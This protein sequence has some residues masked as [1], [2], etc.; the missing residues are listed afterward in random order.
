[1]S[2]RREDFAAFFRALHREDIPNGQAGDSRLFAPFPWQERLLDCVLDT[3]SWPQQVVAPTGAGKTS[4][5]DVHVFGQAMCPAED[6]ERPPRRLA[7]VVDRRVLVDD[8]HEYAKR[9]QQR[10]LDAPEGTVLAEVRRALRDLREVGESY[11]RPLDES[12]VDSPLLVGR[13]RGGA[14]PSR[15]WRDHPTAAAIICGTPDM[16]GSRLLFRGYGSSSRAWPREAGLLAVDS[17][18]VVDEAHLARQLLVTARRVAELVQL[19]QDPVTW[20]ALQVVETTATP[21]QDIGEG[22]V[23]R[24]AT[25]V[26]ERDLDVSALR[27]RLTR[28]KPVKLVEVPDWESTKQTAKVITPLADEVVSLVA[29]T[30]TMPGVASTVGCFVNTV[31]RAVALADELR[32]RTLVGRPL[33]VVMIC[34]QVRP[35]D[36]EQVRTKHPGLLSAAGNGEV[37]V[38]VS[39]QS[40]EVGV[41]LDLAGIVTELASGSAVA[42]R[43][44]RVN[45]RGLRPAGP[46]VVTLPVGAIPGSDLGPG[47]TDKTR[48]GPYGDDELRT[49][50]GWL[51]ERSAD[52]QGLAPWQL[53]VH[54]PPAGARRRDH[55][56]QPQV[57]DAWHWA[58][59]SDEL[60][61]EPEL[62]LWLGEDF[63]QDTSAGLVVRNRMP[64][65]SA[66]A[67]QLVTALPPQPQEV[68][69]VPYRMLRKVLVN[70]FQPYPWAYSAEPHPAVDDPSSDQ[71]TIEVVVVRGDQVASLTW[72]G[73]GESS[74]P[75]IRPGDIVVVDSRHSLFTVSKAGAAFSPPVVVSPD[76]YRA[77]LPLG[78]AD[79][80]LDAIGAPSSADLVG[81]VV[82]RIEPALIAGADGDGRWANLASALSDETLTV[83]Q[84][85]D[86]VSAWLRNAGDHVGRATMATA[87]AEILKR[88]RRSRAEQ[89]RRAQ[90]VIHRDADG[91]LRRVVVLDK[92]RAAT[93]E[94]LR[95]VWVPGAARVLLD[96][97]QRHVGERASAIAQALNLGDELVEALQL[98]GNHHD[99]GKADPRFQS[100]L[101]AVDGEVLAKSD[102]TLSFAEVRAHEEH[103]GLPARWRH[104]QRSVA[105][106][107]ATIRASGVRD[108]GLVARLVGTTHGHGRSGFPHTAYG[109]LRD[110]DDPAI[111]STAAELFDEGVWDDV[112]EDT[113]VRYGPWGCAYLEALLRAADGQVSM[114]GS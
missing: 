43:A 87:A 37:D 86:V 74:S 93:D 38:L 19:T 12:E 26:D 44:G 45:R 50:I 96:A 109:L 10:L 85:H 84:Q 4:V 21:A 110:D 114:E 66:D 41:D 22:H 97:H 23:V 105:E 33:R 88:G 56:Q 20:R 89:L 54:Q 29:G 16:W 35:Y 76:D 95:Q 81:N 18:V 101:G 49:A 17:V 75:S 1:M 36:L 31:G 104:E 14:P 58:R 67:I 5:I 78:L 62:D 98:A 100:R 27:D 30:N 64:A 40:L 83:G 91:A 46:I 60:A 111:V 47:I 103:S 90:L 25:G 65:D 94:E 108:P 2:L 72:R 34:G 15:R 92:R 8:Q 79:D 13:L 82:F 63:D 11:G 52:P 73:S 77:D 99:D 42:Q 9:V 112:I 53:R 7:M 28:P 55:Y 39:T 57:A 106:S 51:V 3:G 69:S 113:Q 6:R 32:H 68:F 59:T 48:S 107:W 80:V 71:S 102:P 70:R 61:A 24:P